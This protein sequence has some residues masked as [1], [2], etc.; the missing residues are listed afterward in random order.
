MSVFWLF[1]WRKEE[2]VSSIEF[3]H[4]IVG[5]KDSERG[6]LIRLVS[7]EFPFNSLLEAGCGVGQNLTLISRLIP[8]IRLTGADLSSK[9]LTEA[10]ENL[11]NSPC[12]S[13]TLVESDLTAM[14]EFKNKSFDIVI[15]SAVLLYIAGD[16]IEKVVSEL[17]R[18][19]SRKLFILEQHQENP[20]FVN[21][22]QGVFV[23]RPGQLSGY[24][25]RDYKK[26]LE[27][28]VSNDRIEIIDVKKPKWEGEKWLQYAKVIITNVV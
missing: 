21:Q 19:T 11:K 14:S 17:L 23:P 25:L 24:W 4:R 10:R 16:E 15:V 27:R 22:H 18:V 6:T 26:L 8:S 20:G 1:F 13:I 7:E 2:I 3:S 28:F 12:K 9:A 5:L